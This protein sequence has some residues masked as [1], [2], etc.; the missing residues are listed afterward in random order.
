MTTKKKTVAQQTSQDIADVQKSVDVLVS[1]LAITQDRIITVLQRLDA[2][3][4]TLQAR[5]NS[6]ESGLDS[7]LRMS[8]ARMVSQVNRIIAHIEAAA[9]S[10]KMPATEK[11]PSPQEQQAVLANHL[12]EAIKMHKARTG[13]GL[14]ESKDIIC[15][16]KDAEGALRQ[17]AAQ[18]TPEPAQNF[19]DKDATHLTDYEQWLANQA[20][21]M[22]IG[23]PGRFDFKIKAIKAV[24][25]RTYVGLKEAKEL[26]E[27]VGHI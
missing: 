21:A 3:A 11:R 25:E 23:S 13:L 14:K 8:E 24:R 22:E 5:F 10:S 2:L 26:V 15:A 17:A 18:A 12:I 19:T 6:L 20:R 16:W 9:T 1:E 7:G 27:L 4:I